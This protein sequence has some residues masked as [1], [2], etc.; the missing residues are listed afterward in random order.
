MYGDY[1]QHSVYAMP[2]APKPV[3][4]ALADHPGR[5]GHLKQGHLVGGFPT[6]ALVYTQHQAVDQQVNLQSAAAQSNTIWF[7]EPTSLKGSQCW[8][9][10]HPEKYNKTHKPINAGEGAQ[11]AE[12]RGPMRAVSLSTSYYSGGTD[13]GPLYL[14]YI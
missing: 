5:A 3:P 10:G 7:D 4:E 9:G 13:R 8:W 2:V 11:N 6:V 14:N 12:I 1:I